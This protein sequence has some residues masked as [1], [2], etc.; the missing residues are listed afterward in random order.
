MLDSRMVD[1][2]WRRVFTPYVSFLMLVL[3]LV[4]VLAAAPLL[5]VVMRLCARLLLIL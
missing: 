4:L 2:V 5:M 1:K 3:I